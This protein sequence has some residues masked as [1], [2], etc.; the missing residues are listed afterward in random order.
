[1]STTVATVTKNLNIKKNAKPHDKM[2]K[3]QTT[4]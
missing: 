1:M 3:K 4:N 2:W